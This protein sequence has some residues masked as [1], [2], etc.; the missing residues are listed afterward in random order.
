MIS[1]CKIMENY[2]KSIF[3]KK[4]IVKTYVHFYQKFSYEIIESDF[5]VVMIIYFKQY[6]TD[7]ILISDVNRHKTSLAIIYM[8]LKMYCYKCTC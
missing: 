2:R 7:K 3:P 5:T 8:C 6:C 1:Y 4:D